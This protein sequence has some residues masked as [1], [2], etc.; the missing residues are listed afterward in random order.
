MGFPRK[1][2]V[3]ATTDGS[4]AAT[5]YTEAILG[6]IIA[7]GYTKSNFSDGVDFTITTEDLGQ[8]VWTDTN[9]NASEIVYPKQLNDDVLGAD[10]TAIYDHIRAFNE[11]IK[12]VVASGG[13]ATTGTFTVYYE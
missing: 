2:S 5:V 8:G 9:I 11:R 1:A 4:G 10:L 6:K 13:A 3:T 12:I 7:I